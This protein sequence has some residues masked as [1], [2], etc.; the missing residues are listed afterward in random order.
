[1]QPLAAHVIIVQRYSDPSWNMGQSSNWGTLGSFFLQG[2]AVGQFWGFVSVFLYFFL[3]KPEVPNF[4][5]LACKLGELLIQN[6]LPFFTYNIPGTSSSIFIGFWGI[7]LWANM[8]APGH[9][10]PQCGRAIAEVG[11][12]KCYGARYFR[13]VQ[14][15]RGRKGERDTSQTSETAAA[16]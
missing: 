4:G 7:D 15:S 9:L 3:S 16:V 11:R 13:S 5:A 1:M 14:R 12:P 2:E 6:S 8:R 10:V